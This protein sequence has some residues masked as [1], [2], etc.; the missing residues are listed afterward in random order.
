MVR[1]HE[2]PTKT[3]DKGVNMSWDNIPN[4]NR[5]RY[6]FN[7]GDTVHVKGKAKIHIVR[8]VSGSSVYVEGRITPFSSNQLIKLNI[9]D[10]IAVVATYDKVEDDINNWIN[11]EIVEPT[12]AK[13]TQSLE[14]RYTDIVGN[15]QSMSN[16]INDST[17][18]GSSA[19]L[20]ALF[21][22]AKLALNEYDT[23]KKKDTS[24]WISKFFGA[25]VQKDKE[26]NSI[27]KNIDSLF[28]LIHNKYNALV[29][30]GEKF[31]KLK[32][33]MTKQYDELEN[34]RLES[35]TEMSSYTDSNEMIPMRLISTNSQ[36]EA[37]CEAYKAKL[38]KIEAGITLTTGAVIALGSKLPSM[39]SG[40]ADETAYAALISSV[41][42]VHGMVSNMAD[43][44]LGV[45]DMTSNEV[46]KK[47][48]DIMQSQINDNSTVKYLESRQKFTSDLAEMISGN[49][50]Q[51]SNKLLAES[52][53]IKQI[54]LES[55]A[56]GSTHKLQQ[57]NKPEFSPPAQRLTK[58]QLRSD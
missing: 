42:N 54:A 35:N 39:R 48:N 1:F 37:S 9:K 41:S 38:L 27:N 2:Q 15:I 19:E 31:Q 24:G 11:N 8:T 10:N 56:G 5:T 40:I 50:E 30:T 3:K 4:E 46:H 52:K 22:K 25:E 55:K 43:L 13:P 16:E 58:P 17:E 26:L 12:Q 28:Q 47:V 33:E 21:D 23:I 32:I 6:T 49:A 57:L 36:I 51:L 14:S 20:E 18:L 29:T 45:A 53:V 34:L 44:M 7:V